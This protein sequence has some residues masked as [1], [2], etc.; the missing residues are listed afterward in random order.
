MFPGAGHIILFRAFHHF[1]PCHLFQVGIHIADVSHFV[2]EGSALDIAASRRH[3]TQYLFVPATFGQQTH[4]AEPV[5]RTAK[6][7][8]VPPG[9]D[10]SNCSSVEGSPPQD[11]MR[12][13]MLPP[14]LSEACSLNPNVDRCAVT[15]LF[16]VDQEVH[17]PDVQVRVVRY[18][19]Y[20]LF[21]GLQ[22]GHASGAAKHYTQCC[23]TDLRI[24]SAAF[25]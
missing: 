3:A 2:S 4:T 15:V 8:T 16:V 18:Y 12:I 1:A 24:G 7:V 17:I 5:S 21:P 6:C 11:I 25:G 23:S 10:E 14:S 9:V 22:F 19:F 20:S 13:P